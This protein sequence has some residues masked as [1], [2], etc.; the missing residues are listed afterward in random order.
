V[1]EA[2]TKK[3]P[4]AS[5]YVNAASYTEPDSLNI[6]ISNDALKVQLTWDVTDTALTY[7]V[8]RA[9]AVWPKGLYNYTIDNVV[10]LGTFSSPAKTVK[11]ADYRE[12]KV[13]L[14]DDLTPALTVRRSYLYKVV[15][16][17][18]GV[19]GNPSY[20][21]LNK[22]AYST[23]S[24]LGV[25]ENT[26]SNYHG[27]M[28][29]IQ[30]NGTYWNDSPSSKPVIKVYRRQT[31]PGTT[32]EYLTG[33]DITATAF[34]EARE[35]SGFYLFVDV[36][37]DG[38]NYQYKFVVTLGTTTEFENKGF[39]E[40]E[41]QPHFISISEWSSVQA[42]LPENLSIT[43]TL[44]L[45]FSDLSNSKRAPI[46]VQYK[47]TTDPVTGWKSASGITDD[48]ASYSL[49]NLESNVS[50]DIQVKRTDVP[51]SYVNVSGYTTPR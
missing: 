49:G 12:N 38:N 29:I 32:Y 44:V 7:E 33:K 26:W 16:I 51:D 14:T 34:E 4:P 47:K 46:T 23:Q 36:P 3:S 19:K 8:S 28:I 18:N 21:A 1:A 9:E 40:I 31:N 39:S 6:Q 24:Y 30:D 5:T 15:P 48:N 11:A 45:N 41:V 37:P 20:E 42:N 2:E 25:S 43:K 50:Y 22:G 10:S 17:K 27:V 13:I 35:Q